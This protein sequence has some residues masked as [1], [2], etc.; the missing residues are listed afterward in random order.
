MSELTINELITEIDEICG[1]YSPDEVSTDFEFEE[2]EVGKS[3]GNESIVCADVYNICRLY[4]SDEEG[5]S[6]N[7]LPDESTPSEMDANETTSKEKEIQIKLFD[8]LK[9]KNLNPQ[10]G[11]SDHYGN[12]Y[13]LTD[14]HV[15]EIKPYKNS[16]HALGEILGY[17]DIY[18]NRIKV[19]HLFDVFNND[20]NKF[21][22]LCDKN[23]VKV[24]VE[25]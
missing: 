2:S 18:P 23:N 1:L 4:S 8:S 6:D 14:L 17:G 20:I 5:E 22:Q 10:M 15:I 16:L 7:D 9:K 24:V 19:I 12:I 11:A 3:E 13:I 25:Y 21:K